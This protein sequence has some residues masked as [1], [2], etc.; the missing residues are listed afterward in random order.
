MDPR[1]FHF[2]PVGASGATVVDG[3]APHLVV[4]LRRPFST[5][6]GDSA[7]AERIHP[8]DAVV[9]LMEQTF[10][11][12]RFGPTAPRLADAR[13]RSATATSSP[14]G[15][16]SDTVD[17]IEDLFRLDPVEPAR[18]VRPPAERGLQP[19]RRLG[20]AR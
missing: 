4:L 7:V 18:R 14:S 8:A 10:D 9:A 2:V 11:A 17:Q 5:N 20:A 1:I 3:G 15:T 12:E 13:P 19:G 6:P 16:P